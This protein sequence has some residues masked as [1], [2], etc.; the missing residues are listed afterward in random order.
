MLASVLLRQDDGPGLVRPV[1]A[2]SVIEVPVGVYQLFYG[3]CIDRRQGFGNLGASGCDFRINEQLS[4]GAGENG[5]IST[6]AQKQADISAKSLHRDL[7]IGGFLER[8][9][10]SVVFLGEE[11]PCLFDIFRLGGLSRT[12]P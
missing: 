11:A 5:N 4:V 3:V 8:I 9:V 2:T 7:C 6:R 12:W 10:N 1:V